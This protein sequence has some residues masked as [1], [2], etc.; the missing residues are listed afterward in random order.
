VASVLRTAAASY[1]EREVQDTPPIE[2]DEA[3]PVKR[4]DGEVTRLGTISF[5]GGTYCEV[6]VGQWVKGGGAKVE[7]EKVSLSLT[8]SILLMELFVGSLESTSHTH[9]TREGA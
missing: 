7:V 1:T 4:L 3:P 9:V 5:S 6:W 2:A 8:T